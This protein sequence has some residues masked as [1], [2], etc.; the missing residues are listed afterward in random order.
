MVGYAALQSGVVAP[1]LFKAIVA[2]APVTDI[3]RLRE[4]Y[5][6]TS[7]QREA[8]D[9]FGTGPHL[10]AGSPAQNAARITAPVLMFHGTYDQNVDYDQAT[11]MN[12][13]LRDAGKRHELVTY[14]R[15][16]HGLEDSNA[17]A[18]LLRRSDAF[19]RQAFGR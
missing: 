1:D 13:K 16:A 2:V 12:D 19:L 8:R 4:S 5:Y 18:D 14:P 15:L 10:V 9:Y 6:R 3:A 11:L 7:A 17:R